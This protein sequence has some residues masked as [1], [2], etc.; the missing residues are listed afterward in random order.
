M[1]VLKAVG[2]MTLGAGRLFLQSWA[3]AS[4][5]MVWGG[6]LGA[7]M[8]HQRGYNRLE[9]LAKGAA[10]GAAVAGFVPTATLLRAT[11]RSALWAGKAAFGIGKEVGSRLAITGAGG[12]EATKAAVM[13]GNI[14]PRTIGLVPGTIA[15]TARWL[16]RHPT[17]SM[18]MG[19]IGF[20]YYR[21]FAHPEES[22]G[23][24]G[25]AYAAT[26]DLQ[27]RTQQLHQST[28]GLVQG[29]HLGRHGGY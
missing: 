20:L 3:H 18:G 2:K 9:D 6:V 14:S 11:E 13:A 24:I 21:M 29:L 26:N 8:A 19:S 15:N 28:S 5:R 10:M 12:W 25:Q 22:T 27:R 16:A 23:V 4:T 1:G 17:L 7:Y